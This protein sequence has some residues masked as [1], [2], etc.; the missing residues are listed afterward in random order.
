VGR[1]GGWA[2]GVANQSR[3]S[4]SITFST[5]QSDGSRLYNMVAGK[6]V[7]KGRP[8]RGEKVW[9]ALGYGYCRGREERATNVESK[10]VCFPTF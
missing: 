6:L 1:G 2:S 5:S 9:S 10:G 7:R 4:T 3:L 8:R